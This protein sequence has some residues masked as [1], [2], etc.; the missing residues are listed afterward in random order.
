M[1]VA[2]RGAQREFQGSQ[3]AAPVFR[4]VAIGLASLWGL[5]PESQGAA[6]RGE[7]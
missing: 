6:A 7:P 4:D 1:A 2:V 3:V 5:P